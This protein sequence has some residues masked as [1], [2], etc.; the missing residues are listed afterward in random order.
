MPSE[1]GILRIRG[2]SKRRTHVTLWCVLRDHCCDPSAQRLG[3]RERETS[4][5]F[6]SMVCAFDAH[7]KSA[8]ALDAHQ[9]VSLS[10]KEY[11]MSFLRSLVA[12]IH[13]RW[14]PAYREACGHRR[15]GKSVGLNIS[16]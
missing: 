14:A 3:V 10:K 8:C 1:L 16:H 6:S 9:R 15:L 4:Q 7:M 12:T 5:T 11:F 13:A 2:Q